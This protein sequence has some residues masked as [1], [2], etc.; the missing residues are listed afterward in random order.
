LVAL[1]ILLPHENESAAPAQHIIGQVAMARHFQSFI[2][3]VAALTCGCETDTRSVT[4]ELAFYDSKSN[5]FATVTLVL[6][7]A[8]SSKLQEGKWR[9]ELLPTYV[10]PQTDYI[11]AADKF[12]AS[13]WRPLT[14]LRD[15]EMSSLRL[16]SLH[17]KEPD[18]YV[19]VCVPTSG[20]VLTGRW[21]YAT[22]AGAVESGRITGSLSR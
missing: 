3:S 2:L 22:D 6:P 1:R 21:W 8:V 12:V 7:A 16:I 15:P 4:T 17:P 5:R 18:D 14:S 20:Q 13:D 9:G 19:M 11:V 10:R